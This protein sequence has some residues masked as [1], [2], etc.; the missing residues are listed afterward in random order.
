MLFSVALPDQ[1]HQCIFDIDISMFADQKIHLPST[2]QSTETC[3]V[4]TAHLL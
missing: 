3:D 4:A 2:K 1:T